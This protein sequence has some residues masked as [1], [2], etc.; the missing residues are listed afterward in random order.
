MKN[1]TLNELL[2]E[3]VSCFSQSD[4]LQKII[5]EAVKSL[6]S[7]LINYIFP[8]IGISADKCMH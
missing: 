5:D 7:D 1:K 4:E 2:T 3:G 8:L 6:F